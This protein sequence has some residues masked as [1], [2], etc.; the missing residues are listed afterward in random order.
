MEDSGRLGRG[1]AHRVQGFKHTALVS[2][3]LSTMRKGRKEGPY[4]AQS[5]LKALHDL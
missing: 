2:R 1:P 3:W 5:P 4:L